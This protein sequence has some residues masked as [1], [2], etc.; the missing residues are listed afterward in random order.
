MY[1]IKFSVIFWSLCL[2]I[3]RRMWRKKAVWW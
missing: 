1:N 3:Y 2:W